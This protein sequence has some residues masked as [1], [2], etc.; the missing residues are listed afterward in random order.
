MVG[1]QES[2]AVCAGKK[3]I[4]TLNVLVGMNLLLTTDI[5][6]SAV[7]QTPNMPK[8]K[9][10]GGNIEDQHTFT[11]ADKYRQLVRGRVLS[12]SERGDIR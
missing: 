2:I 5:V 6:M 9:K 4:F 3:H 10:T 8:D 11:P 1:L 7:K 12:I